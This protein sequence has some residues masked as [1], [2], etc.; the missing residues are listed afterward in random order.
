M[1]NCVDTTISVG[2]DEKPS[3]IT[4][5]DSNGE[6]VWR[7]TFDNSKG[8]IIYNSLELSNGDIVLAGSTLNNEGREVGWLY[9]TD[10]NGNELWQR[11][12]QSQVNDIAVTNRPALINNIK[13]TSDGGLIA[14]GTAF[15]TS[16]ASDFWVLKLDAYGCVEP[17]CQ[18]GINE[19]EVNNT[20]ILAFP[21]PAKEHTTLAVKLHSIN[22]Y[23]TINITCYDTQGKAIY[24]TTATLYSSGYTE[25]NINTATW[26]SGIYYYTV[27]AGNE[28][29]GSGKIIVQ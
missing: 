10:A 5:I 15:G 16:N 4:R 6:I 7:S 11:Q 2:A 3:Q 27:N 14:V 29:V 28:E 21:N 13:E 25:Q 22:A 9:K 8:H 1:F 26:S 12:Y 18:V 20:T 24:T 19:Q 23:K 17:G